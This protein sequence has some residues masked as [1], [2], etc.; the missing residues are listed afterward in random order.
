MSKA[1]KT[2]NAHTLRTMHVFAATS[3]EPLHYS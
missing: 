3:C 2:T 1:R